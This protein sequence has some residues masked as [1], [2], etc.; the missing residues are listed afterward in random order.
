MSYQEQIK[1]FK[2]LPKIHPYLIVKYTKIVTRLHKRF[3]NSF[4][5]FFPCYHLTIAKFI[6]YQKIINTLL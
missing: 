4:K 1:S 6:T 5:H 3:S 2:I